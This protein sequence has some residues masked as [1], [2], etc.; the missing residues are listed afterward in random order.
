[1]Q[2]WPTKR[3]RVADRGLREGLLAEMMNGDGAWIKRPKDR[4]RRKKNTRARNAEGGSESVHHNSKQA[5]SK[6]RKT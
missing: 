2:T 4:W 1:R 6:G 5:S 3:L